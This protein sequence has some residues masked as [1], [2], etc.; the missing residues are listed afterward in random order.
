MM[1]TSNKK[2]SNIKEA[3]KVSEKPFG[4]QSQNHISSESLFILHVN[5][6]ELMQFQ[7]LETLGKTVVYKSII[8]GLEQLC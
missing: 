5:C 1:E 4:S 2:R 7:S 8:Q 6:I 3:G